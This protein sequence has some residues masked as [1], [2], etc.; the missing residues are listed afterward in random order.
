MTRVNAG[1][2]TAVDHAGTAYCGFMLH[3]EREKTWGLSPYGRRSFVDALAGG[4]HDCEPR[5]VNL[6]KKNH[7]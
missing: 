2:G 1:L 7:C 3:G 5:C 4:V 6:I